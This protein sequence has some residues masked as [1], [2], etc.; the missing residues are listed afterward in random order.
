MFAPP[1]LR[2]R[3]RPGCLNGANVTLDESVH[4]ARYCDMRPPASHVWLELFDR[5]EDATVIV[6]ARYRQ[7]ATDDPA[8][9]HNVFPSTPADLQAWHK[10][11]QLHAVRTP[12]A[13]VGLLAVAPGRIGW[14]AGDEIN[15]EVV[16]VNHHG[17]G[18][19]AL[20]QAAWAA[21]PARDQ[22]QLLIGTIDRLNTSS[23][24]TARAA[25]RRR[26]LDELFISL[27][28]GDPAAVTGRHVG[29]LITLPP[30]SSNCVSTPSVCRRWPAAGALRS[31]S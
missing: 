16:A 9:A 20:A 17:H 7:L 3:T 27:S 12:D 23:R 2:L 22:H 18:Y 14:I 25:G 11:G 31:T 13:I 10:S 28:V 15:E 21:Q 30:C 29:N 5:V 8:L 19:A 26:V 6:N 4:L 24:K 1:V